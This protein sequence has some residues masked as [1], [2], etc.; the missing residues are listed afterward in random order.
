MMRKG[1]GLFA[2]IAALS[3]AY[4]AFGAPPSVFEKVS[5][6]FYVWRSQDQGSNTGVLLSEVGVLLINPPSEGELDDFL[7]VLRN[8]TSKPVR[9]IVNT[10]YR[11]VLAGSNAYFHNLG[12]AAIG[13]R[14]QNRL[15]FLALEKHGSEAA[16]PS[17]VVTAPEAAAPPAPSLPTPRFEFGRRMHIYPGGIDV[18]IFALA[19]S[20]TAGDI[21]VFVPSEKIVQTGD[22]FL[23][24]AYPEIDAQ[25]GEGSA[26]GWIDAMRQIIE[27]VPLLKS[28]MPPPEPDPDAPPE[29]EKT[30]EELVVVV[31][32]HGPISDL[33]QVK[34]MFE[35]ARRLRTVASR[36][37]KAGQSRERFLRSTP[38]E[39]RQYGN[40]EP[41]AGLLFDDLTGQLPDAKPEV[42]D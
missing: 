3:L 41:F 12:A 27:A 4:V 39:V 37:A 26:V 35:A 40:Y 31:P 23:P 36:A 30:L 8:V 18:H 25:E 28:A 15:A 29:E 2:V 33:Q 5:D 24:G 17:D 32:G 10:D 38:L 1:F 14:E 22:V 7:R 21:C 34:D 9:W 13:T 6:H 11:H 19:K 20:V 16:P 42:R